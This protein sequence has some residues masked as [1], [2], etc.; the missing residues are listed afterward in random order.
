MGEHNN[1]NIKLKV[2]L[3]VFWFF[4]TI[5]D[6]TDGQKFDTIDDNSKLSVRK[7]RK[8]SINHLHE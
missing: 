3:Y 5:S 7:S 8:K 1:K 4:G 2:V 6:S